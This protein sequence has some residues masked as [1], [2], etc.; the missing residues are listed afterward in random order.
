MDC[1]DGLFCDHAVVVMSAFTFDFDLEDDLDES[2]GATGISPQEPAAVP[3]IDKTLV[4]EGPPGGATPAEEITLSAL[5]RDFFL[6]LFFC[7][8]IWFGSAALHS[9]RSVLVFAYNAPRS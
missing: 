3:S 1:S 5:V 7:N 8:L 6:F 2:F 9:P 4:S